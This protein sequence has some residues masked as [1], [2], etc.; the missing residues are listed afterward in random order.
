VL[1][2]AQI[3]N[4]FKL[5]SNGVI[6]G[7][8]VLGGK[9]ARNAYARLWRGTEL[10][11]EGVITSLKRFKEDVKE[12]GAGYECGISLDG[13]DGYKLDDEIEAYIKEQINK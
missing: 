6:A 7:S 4:I 3:R 10:V 2:R 9:I 12:I 8:Y 5:S 13:Y 11:H 1:G